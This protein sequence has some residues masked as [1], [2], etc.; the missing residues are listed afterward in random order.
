[1][2]PYLLPVCMAGIFCIRENH[3]LNAWF[4]SYNKAM[5][6]AT[7]WI[8]SFMMVHPKYHDALEAIWSR[9]QMHCHNESHVAAATIAIIGNVTVITSIML[10]I[11]IVNVVAGTAMHRL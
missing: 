11:A 5:D 8:S 9:L 10:A 4:S 7:A 2:I 6:N 3:A 1:M